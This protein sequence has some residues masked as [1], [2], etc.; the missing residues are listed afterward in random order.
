MSCLL[1]INWKYNGAIPGVVIKNACLIPFPHSSRCNCKFWSNLWVNWWFLS[2]FTGYS[3][4]NSSS[5]SP[6]LRTKMFNLKQVIWSLLSSVGWK[7]YFYFSSTISLLR[8]VTSHPEE[9]QK[10]K[11]LLIHEPQCKQWQ[12]IKAN[13][14][15]LLALFHLEDNELHKDIYS[16]TWAPLHPPAF[17]LKKVIIPPLNSVIAL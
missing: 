7:V 11:S 3:P 16:V 2:F 12:C 8:K 4:L 6:T 17:H 9:K 10:S 15:Y 5:F 14:V 1:F 13:T